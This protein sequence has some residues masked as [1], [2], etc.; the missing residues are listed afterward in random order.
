MGPRELEPGVPRRPSQDW[1]GLRDNSRGE[2]ESGG[3]PRD[4]S[5]GE[6][7]QGFPEDRLSRGARDNR[8]EGSCSH[9]LPEARPQEG[10]TGQ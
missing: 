10:T 9:G 4:N 8:A 1:I 5:R 2:L 6:L 3:R 7:S